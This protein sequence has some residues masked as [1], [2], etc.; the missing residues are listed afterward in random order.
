VP[1]HPP[2]TQPL[3]GV[4]PDVPLL[5]PAFGQGAA[6][7]PTRLHGHAF[8][9]ATSTW[10]R[11]GSDHRYLLAS[12]GTEL[13][14]DNPLR[15][16]DSAH[17]RGTLDRREFHADGL[18]DETTQGRIERLSWRWGDEAG[19]PV[20]VEAGRFLQ[21]TLPELGLLDGV[22]V[23]APTPRLGSFG[24]SFGGAPEPFPTKSTGDDLQLALFWLYAAGEAEQ[25]VATLGW[26]TT[27]HDG[28][29]DRDVLVGDVRWRPAEE[30]DVWAGTWVDWYHGDDVIKA[31]G[32]E[33]TELHLQANWRWTPAH[34]V[35]VGWDHLRWPELLRREFA[36][37]TPDQIRDTRVDRA[38]LRTWHGLG[39]HLWLDG[40][41]QRWDDQSAAGTN[42][43]VRLALRDLL[44]PRGE[45]A[46]TGFHHEGSTSTG[47]GARL[48]A[49][50]SA[51]RGRYELGGE[52]LRLTFEPPAGGPDLDLQ[53]LFGNASWSL[54]DR[55]DLTV[56]IDHRFG[57]AQH[58]LTL[59]LFG[60]TRF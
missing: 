30:F 27:W 4:A 8:G 6:A 60:Q 2:W 28:D 43:D 23:L 34:G 54:T 50:F 32:F 57:D 46:V 19:S 21:S 26:Q 48:S 10:D 47:N 18:D 25:L 45:L 15:L 11:G 1:D 12:M 17:F 39:K 33:L 20:R 56:T 14:L 38:S 37:L 24:F 35:G 5:A 36:A 55:T 42:G 3:E 22:E 7:R 16:G 59:G 49:S 53:A 52:W 40:G 9:N 58:V 41:I 51:G 44:W 31:H 29:H 13:S